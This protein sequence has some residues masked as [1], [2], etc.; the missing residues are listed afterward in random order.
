MNRKNEKKAIRTLGDEELTTVSGGFVNC[1]GL[2]DVAKGGGAV[3]AFVQG[4]LNG[5]GAAGLC[6]YP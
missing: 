3:G 5:L 6:R 2:A 4:Y 1:S